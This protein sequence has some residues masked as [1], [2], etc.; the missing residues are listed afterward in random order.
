[1][2]SSKDKRATATD[3]MEAATAALRAEVER[4][5]A[6]PMARLA[7][8][9]MV[10][11]FGPGDP[12]IA[13]P[14]SFGALPN[15]IRGIVEKYK[16]LGTR[17]QG[18]WEDIISRGDKYGRDVLYGRLSAVVGEGLQVLEHQSLIRTATT[19]DDTSGEVERI[20]YTLTRR[21]RAALEA[22]AVEQA[23]S[24]AGGEPA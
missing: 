19:E 1:M 15:I 8:E 17:S 23:L 24:G 22:N 18:P 16:S 10:R 2:F 6:L 14:D 4:L 5:E 9:V 3:R 12:G 11:G 21:G 13:R 7:A 20:Y